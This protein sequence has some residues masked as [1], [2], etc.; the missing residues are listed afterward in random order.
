MR[1]CTSGVM[2]ETKIEKRSSFR[3]YRHFPSALW[4]PPAQHL[5]GMESGVFSLKLILFLLLLLFLR[6]R[7]G[8]REGERERERER[9]R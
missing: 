4:Q 8:G 9:E 1:L 3:Q 5:F 7:E 2:S 6:R